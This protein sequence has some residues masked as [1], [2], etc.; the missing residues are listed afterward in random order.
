MFS[1]CSDEALEEVADLA[2][3]FEVPDGSVLIE[4]GQAGTGLFIIEEGTVRVDLPDGT[5]VELGEGEFFGELAVVSD[6]PRTAR[7]SASSDLKGLAIRRGEM[8]DL[9]ERNGS[10]AVAILREVGQRLAGQLEPNP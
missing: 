5:H 6:T 2:T 3:E 1:S 8:L 9:L 7:V 10:L 4:R